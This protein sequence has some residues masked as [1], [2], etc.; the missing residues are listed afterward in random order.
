ME[1]D[2]IGQA[3]ESSP[4]DVLALNTAMDK[5]AA[6]DPEDYEIVMLRYFAGLSTEETAHLKSV[7]TRTVERRWRFCRAW[8][9]RELEEPAEA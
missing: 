3:L 5:L 6:E 4:E 2:E 7:S 9:P 1:L 8:L